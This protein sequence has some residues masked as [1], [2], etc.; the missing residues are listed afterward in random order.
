MKVFGMFFSEEELSVLAEDL[1]YTSIE[2]ISQAGDWLDQAGSFRMKPAP[3]D[4]RKKKILQDSLENMPLYINAD[5]KSL[6]TIAS[7]R[8]KIAR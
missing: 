3:L 2:K 6:R 4:I 1:G 7:W 5:S 8:L